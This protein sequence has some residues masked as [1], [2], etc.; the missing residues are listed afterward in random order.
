MIAF[1]R[2]PAGDREIFVTR[3]DGVG[4]ARKLTSE[5]GDARAP[6]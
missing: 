5:G 4:G 3:A 2:G 6:D 1:V